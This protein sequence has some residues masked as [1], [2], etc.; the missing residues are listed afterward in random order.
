MRYRYN[1][2]WFFFLLL[3]GIISCASFSSYK[4]NSNLDAIVKDIFYNEVSWVRRGNKYYL[5]IDRKL[6]QYYDIMNAFSDGERYIEAFLGK[7][8]RLFY[9]KRYRKIEGQ[10]ILFIREDMVEYKKKRY[11]ISLIG[12]F[13]NKEVYLIITTRG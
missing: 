7:G 11:K 13:Y 8:R 4:L 12:D 1:Q 3:W 6:I 10:K 2:L 5:F 9:T